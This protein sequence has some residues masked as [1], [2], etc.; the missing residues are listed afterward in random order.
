MHVFQG[1]KKKVWYLNKKRHAK[2]KLPNWKSHW[3][4]RN[5][6]TKQH[7]PGFQRHSVYMLLASHRFVLTQG[8]SISYWLFSL[9]FFF[10]VKQDDK[11]FS[12]LRKTLGSFLESASDDDFPPDDW[13]LQY[14]EI[15]WFIHSHWF[16]SFHWKV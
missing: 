5:R 13:R 6:Y 15:L 11:T 14:K 10:F 2:I 8:T 1:R 16:Y 9:S 12:I 7:D 3:K 4:R